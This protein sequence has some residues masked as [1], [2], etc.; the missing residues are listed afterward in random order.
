MDL[1]PK[2]ILTIGLAQL[3]ELHV[4]KM[5]V[6]INFQ[7]AKADFLLISAFSTS[8]ISTRK[9]YLIDFQVIA[10][11][12]LCLYRAF[13]ARLFRQFGGSIPQRSHFE[14]VSPV[15]RL[16]CFV[17]LRSQLHRLEGHN[18]AHLSRECLAVDPG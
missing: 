5:V 14:L 3:K 2:N 10:K 12:G 7:V 13:E 17:P 8:Q 18:F 1:I 15:S 9:V 4:P 16:C 11:Y 6:P